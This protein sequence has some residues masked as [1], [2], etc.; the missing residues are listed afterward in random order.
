MRRPGQGECTV[1]N[2][3][4][5]LCSVSDYDKHVHGTGF[6]VNKRAVGSILRFSPISERLCMIKVKS[7]FNNISIINA[8]TPTE[9]VEDNEIDRFYEQLEVVYDQIPQY[10]GMPGCREEACFPTIRR[11]SKHAKSND[12]DHGLIYF[13]SEKSMSIN[14]TMF[15]HKDIYI[16]TWKSRDL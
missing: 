13:A 10:D 7:K 1:E 9:L 8:Y 12:N 5:L 11:H 6:L 14:S 15:A 2:G 16:S 3:S 4:L